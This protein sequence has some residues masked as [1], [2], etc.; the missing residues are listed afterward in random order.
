MELPK[1]SIRRGQVI[2]Q[3]RRTTGNTYVQVRCAHRR[4]AGTCLLFFVNL[5]SRSVI[6]LQVI[7]IDGLFYDGRTQ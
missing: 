5:L 2:V 4:E 3:T 1:V 6:M 7:L